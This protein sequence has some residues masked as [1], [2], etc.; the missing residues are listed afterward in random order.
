MQ[1]RNPTEIKEKILGIIKERGPSLPVQIAGGIALSP[2]FTSAFLS[3]LL[4]EK[5]IKMTHM[6]VGSSP[7]YYLEGQEEGLEKY[8]QYLKSKEKEAYELIRKDRFLKDFE[9]EPAIRVALRA[10]KDFAI[11]IKNS[12]IWRYYLDDEKNYREKD[13]I[14]ENLIDENL[15]EEN[16]SKDKILVKKE[17]TQ[18]I[19]VNKEIDKKEPSNFQKDFIGIV[20]EEILKLNI[21]II[22]KTQTKKKEVYWIGRFENQLGEV[23]VEI[24]GKDKKSVSDKD[25]EKVFEIVKDKKRSVV[26]FSTGELSKKAKEVYREYKNVLLFRKIN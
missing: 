21:K 3:E 5:K 10:I 18:E 14:K 12:E 26:F 20:E 24:V 7:V 1:Q 17:E 22:E 25:L 8:S 4:Q 6:R 15:V 16:S 19:F 23:E 11:P 13:I 2:L 9:Q